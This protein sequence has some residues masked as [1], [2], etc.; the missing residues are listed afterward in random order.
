[1]AINRDGDEAFDQYPRRHQMHAY[2]PDMFLIAEPRAKPEPEQPRAFEP[3]MHHDFFSD[4]FGQ[5][6]ARNMENMEREMQKQMRSMDEMHKQ[7]EE[8][9]KT[10]FAKMPSLQ[11]KDAN[12]SK[13]ESPHGKKSNLTN[14]AANQTAPA[15]KDFA[16]SEFSNSETTT[17]YDA[18]TGTYHV[19]KC[20][21]GKCEKFTQ[22][23]NGTMVAQANQTAPTAKA[24]NT[25]TLSKKAANATISRN[26]T[27]SLSQR[28]QTADA[29]VNRT[30]AANLTAIPVAANKTSNATAVVAPTANAT[31]SEH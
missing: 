30:A 17:E 1:M 9:F 15:V 20:V 14:I 8:R 26:K 11:R 25:T 28:D 27:T 16:S 18:K 10:D 13:L 4:T 31:L 12:A 24:A 29:T 22:F 6:M 21:N 19:E 2:R 5:D 7:M 3:P 23:K